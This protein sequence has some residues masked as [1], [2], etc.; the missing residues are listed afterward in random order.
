[1]PQV[2]FNSPEERLVMVRDL[3]NERGAV[4]ID[5]L[6]ANFG[7]SQMT[8]RRDLDELEALGAARRVR[9]GAIALGPEPF[10]QRHR[11][12][13]RAKSR[14]AEKLRSLV[15]ASGTIALDA[16]TTIYR[17]ASAIDGSRDLTIVTNGPDTFGALAAKPGVTA[18][19]TGGT[20]EPRTDSL[21][22]PVAARAAES[23]TYEAFFC[24][25]AA[26]DADLGSSEASL[27]EADIKRAF[28]STSTRIVLA[29]DQ[30][31]L[32]TTAQA[33]MFALSEIDLL[34][35]DLDPHDARLDKYG[36]VVELR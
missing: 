35:T 20:R 25:G 1:M 8:I 16:S 5:D 15:P 10:S 4:R 22:G 31:K 19:L 2:Q 11:H 27:A 32:N 23:F 13:A 7:V 26:L 28:G 6:A 30:S 24:S 12:N 9:G 14:I 18:F 34:V 36:R 17:L 3:V 21:I 33:R 29:A